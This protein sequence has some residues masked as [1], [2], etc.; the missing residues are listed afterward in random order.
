MK[1]INW[2]SVS[3]LRINVTEKTM[4]IR[5]DSKILLTSCFISWTTWL[6]WTQSNSER[7]FKPW[8]S[9]TQAFQSGSDRTNHKTIQAQLTCLVG[10]N[11]Q[12]FSV[13]RSI[14]MRCNQSSTNFVRQTDTYLSLILKVYWMRT[15]GTRRP[16]TTHTPYKAQEKSISS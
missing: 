15:H 12:T 13:C 11:L 9:A 4:S 16:R 1:Q 3:S 14:A 5:I 6:K 10:W 2:L 7:F 8:K